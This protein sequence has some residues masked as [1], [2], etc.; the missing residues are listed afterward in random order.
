MTLCCFDPAVYDQYALHAELCRA[1]AYTGTVDNETSRHQEQQLM[2]GVV[3][4]RVSVPDEFLSAPELT[5][6]DRESSDKVKS[7]LSDWFRSIDEQKLAVSSTIFWL[8]GLHFTQGNFVTVMEKKIAKSRMSHD[9]IKLTRAMYLMRAY[10]ATVLCSCY[11]GCRDRAVLEEKQLAMRASEPNIADEL[12]IGPH[13][14]E[15][16]TFSHLQFMRF[17]RMTIIYDTYVLSRGTRDRTCYACNSSIRANDQYCMDMSVVG[18]TETA[19]ASQERNKPRQYCLCGACHA[20]F[21]AWFFFYRL[22]DV[23]MYNDLVEFVDAELDRDP[24]CS[25]LTLLQGYRNE[26]LVSMLNLISKHAQELF[27]RAWFYF[28]EEASPEWCRRMMDLSDPFS[29]IESELV[30]AFANEHGLVTSIHPWA[31]DQTDDLLSDDEIEEGA[32]RRHAGRGGANKK[33][34]RTVVDCSD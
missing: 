27:G 1:L 30:N 22:F 24:E 34:R 2:A 10:R 21:E 8:L 18:V 20:I 12:N 28:T 3:K 25:T 29:K 5:Q 14:W 32:K 11:K 23:V 7:R 16:G 15:P 31:D 17:I 4:K 26:R 6:K 33:K 19:P 13:R 9:D